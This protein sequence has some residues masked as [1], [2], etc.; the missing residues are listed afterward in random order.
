MSNQSYSV[1][2]AWEQYFTVSDALESIDTL[3]Y[4]DVKAAELRSIKEPRLMCKFDHRE[5]V[6]EPLRK[7]HVS[8]LAISNTVY[9]L[10]RTDPFIDLDSN[11]F[12]KATSDRVFSLPRHLTT[13]PVNNITSESMAM[14]VAAAS[15]MLNALHE[16]QLTLT[17][18]GRRRS[19]SFQFELRDSTRRSIHYPIEGVQIEIDGGFEGHNHLLL[20]EAKMDHAATMGLRQ[21]LYPE[22]HF[23]SQGI[24]KK[25][26][27][28][29]FVYEPIGRFHFLPFTCNADY[30]E[31]NFD[32][33]NYKLFTIREDSITRDSRD[34]IL[35]TRID[36]FPT[37]C[38]GAPFPQADNFNRVLT[39]MY[40]I[41]QGQ[42]DTVEELFANEALTPRQYSYYVA[43]ARWLGL[44]ER[45]PESGT[46][47]RR[48][49]PTSLARNLMK[50][51]ETE[52]LQ[53]LAQI[54]FSNRLIHLFLESDSP[55][56][57]DEVRDLSGLT[58]DKTF[59]RRM[60]TVLSWKR[61]F[62]DRL[63][64]D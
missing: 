20:I 56:I 37:G 11:R 25:I 60:Q 53:R 51:S 48:Y 42:V 14:D 58:S 46:G 40:R 23:A 17:I 32:Y 34:V 4:F 38:D 35:A 27:S 39:L 62:S 8:V 24:R 43:A 6:S 18:R 21:L 29:Y 19:N 61:Y 3:G 12:P 44:I 5:R 45:E 2:D 9:R 15:G 33:E 59:E 30:S 16:D 57:P 26:T 54:F 22:M 41:L 52:R 31:F 55:T 47:K 50:M 13:L 7:Q 10:A 1:K 64:L 63:K 49:R 36:T 28:Y